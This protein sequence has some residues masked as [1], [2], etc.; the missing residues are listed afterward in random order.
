MERFAVKRGVEKSVGGNAGLCKLAA[1]MFDGAE[2]DSAGKFTASFGLMTSVVGSYEDGKLAVD[3]Q[4]LKGAGLA[5]FLDTKGPEVA[6]E[7]RKR[8]SSFLDQATGYSAKQRGDKAKENAKRISKAKSTIK[9]AHKTLEM[10]KKIDD[11]GKAKI[12]EMIAELE[13]LLE[14][15]EVPSEGKVKKL[16]DML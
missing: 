1:E 4:Q 2:A 8:W 11:A 6:M 16:N 7:S 10:T 15:G 3:V 9:L 14:N 13:Q 12:L 5:E